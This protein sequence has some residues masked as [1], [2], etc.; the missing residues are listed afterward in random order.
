MKEHEIKK[1]LNPGNK[2]IFLFIFFL[3]LATL[4]IG[5]V[6]YKKYELTKDPQNLSE[7][8]SKGTEQEKL[9]VELDIT[10]LPVLLASNSEKDNYLYYVTD[11]NSHTYIAKISNKT[12]QKIQKECDEKNGTLKTAFHLTGYTYLIDSQLKQLALSANNSIFHENELTEDNFSQQLG[13]VYLDENNSPVSSRM[14]TVYTILALLALFFCIIAFGHIL[15]AI[16]K[17]NKINQNQDGAETIRRELAHLHNAPYK[18]Y[19]LYLTEN[20]IIYTLQGP[21]AIRY[22][23]VLWGYVKLQKSYGIKAGNNL[24]VYTRDKQ[25]HLIASA[26]AGNNIL[27]TALAEIQNRAPDMLIGYH[28]DNISYFRDYNSK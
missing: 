1:I 16:I 25:L 8:F 13:T 21:H 11:S 9:Y 20:Y 14:I 23:D 6:F 4:C 27:E 5:V 7:M 10:C 17:T 26:S 19:H 28:K 12:Y 18:K 15:P 3:L 2:L 22:E 24:F